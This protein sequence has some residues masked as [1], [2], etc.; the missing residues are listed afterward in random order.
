MAHNRLPPDAPCPCGSGKKYE[1][2]CYD[3]GFEWLVDEDGTVF[4]SM[5]MPA[6][7]GEIVAEQ[8][9]RF[10]A[11]F[12]REPEP[13]ENL[14]FDAPPLEHIEHEMVQAMKKAGVD[15]AMIHAFEKTG[16]L[17]TED[18]QHLLSDV[19]LAEWEAAIQEYRAK[20]G[21]SDSPDSHADELF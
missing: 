5:P 1:H 19:D 17:V 14:F 21:D 9:Q 6:E 16:L 15:P 10:V 3:K 12:G 11:K 20:H 13:D 18:N 2:C 8:R 7:L 4:K